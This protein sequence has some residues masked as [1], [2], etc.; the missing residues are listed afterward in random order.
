MVQICFALCF[1]RFINGYGG[2]YELDRTTSTFRRMLRFTPELGLADDSEA[3]RRAGLNFAPQILA[4]L[5]EVNNDVQEGGLLDD[6]S[7]RLWEVRAIPAK[8]L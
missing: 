8:S 5:I 2:E 4:W 1:R 3:R 7:L 6:R